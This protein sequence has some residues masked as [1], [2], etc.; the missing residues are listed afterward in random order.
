MRPG[1]TSPCTKIPVAVCMPTPVTAVQSGI[2][3]KNGGAI[4]L[5]QE[6]DAGYPTAGLPDRYMI[7]LFVGKK[8]FR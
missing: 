1:V 8:G 7:D 5:L 3:D 4:F 6:V 2:K